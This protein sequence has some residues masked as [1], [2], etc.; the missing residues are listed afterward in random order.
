MKAI[1]P[2]IHQVSYHKNILKERLFIMPLKSEEYDPRDQL[3]PHNF[4]NYARLKPDAIYA[5]YT[6]SPI[7][8]EKGYRP[9][10]YKEFANAINGIAWWLTETLG[11]GNGEILPYI[12]LND[13]R[14]PALLIGAVKAGYCVCRNPSHVKNKPLFAAL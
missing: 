13:V 14:Y 12:G 9:I 2:N 10:T 7:S 11:P 1:G 8:Y 4:D 3:V 5:E 6:V